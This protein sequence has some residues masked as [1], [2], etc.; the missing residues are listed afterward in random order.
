MPI[1]QLAIAALIAIATAGVAPKAMAN[2]QYIGEIRTFGLNFCPHGWL[3]TDGRTVPH[4]RYAGLFSL[5]GHRYGGSV[6][7]FAL[8]NLP[9]IAT[10]HQGGLHMTQCIA[11]AGLY[12]QRD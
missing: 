6:T 11:W 2:D 8:P 7:E 4:N 10:V 9:P 3:P 12:P 5:I 1:K